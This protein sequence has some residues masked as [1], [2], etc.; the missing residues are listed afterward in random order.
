M[1]DLILNKLKEPSTL[2]GLAMLAGLVGY[3]IAPELLNT[4]IAAVGAVIALIE[5]IRKE[6][7]A[8]SV[9]KAVVAEVKAGDSK[10]PG[11]ITTAGF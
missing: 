9:G 11:V 7:T 2:K 5:V 10:A 6:V 4:I 3:Q 8:K 1:I